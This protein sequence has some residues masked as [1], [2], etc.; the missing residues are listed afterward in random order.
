MDKAKRDRE[1]AA[2]AHERKKAQKA[3]SSRSNDSEA[4]DVSD[5][6]ETPKKA[7]PTASHEG[8]ARI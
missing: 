3:G 5:F 8:T 1:H 2:R 7:A 6:V 4:G